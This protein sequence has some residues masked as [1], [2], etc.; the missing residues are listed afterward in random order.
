MLGGWA[1]VAALVAIL[2]GYGWLRSEFESRLPNR[3]TSALPCYGLKSF[4]A[5]GDVDSFWVQHLGVQF[6]DKWEVGHE[7]NVIAMGKMWLTK[8]SN[9][10]DSELNA[11]LYLQ[12][13]PDDDPYPRTDQIGWAKVTDHEQHGKYASIRLLLS[14]SVIAS[15]VNE[16]GFSQNQSVSVR[17]FENDKG[18]IIITSIHMSPA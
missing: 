14:G 7:L 9:N 4:G 16:L 2:W 18:G 13:S 3:M 1:G 5:Y 17:G 12:F 8:D 10:D 11:R 15:F 6:V